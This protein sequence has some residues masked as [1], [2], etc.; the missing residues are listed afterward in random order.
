MER[1]LLKIRVARY[2]GFCMGVRRAVNIAIDSAQRGNAPVYTLGSLIHNPQVVEALKEKGVLPV[3]SVRGKP[4]GRVI[5]R[6][7]GI[8]PYLR[9]EIE[10]SGFG[11]IDATCPH[12]LR[13]Q[14]II[15]KYCAEG[16]TAVIV[17]DRGHAEVSALLGYARARGVGVIVESEEEAQSL[18]LPGES[19]SDAKLCVVAQT[20]QDTDLYRRVCQRI[21]SRFP[22][23]IICDTICVS[24]SARQETLRELCSQVDAVVVVGGKE[25]ANTARLAEIAASYPVT[26]FHIEQAEELNPEQFKEFSSVGVTAGASTP[27]W[28][29]RSVVKRLKSFG[30]PRSPVATAAK[31]LVRFLVVSNIYLASGAAALC[32]AVSL[33][34]GIAWRIEYS[35]IAFLYIF[36]VHSVNQYISVHKLPFL[37]SAETERF[38]ASLRLAVAGIASGL[39]AMGIS[40]LLGYV[41]FGLL[42]VALIFGLTYSARLLPP[43]LFRLSRL[44]DLPGSKD[45]FSALGWAFVVSLF[46][47][48]DSLASEKILVCTLASLFVFLLVYIRS[49]LLDIGQIQ[50][51]RAVG[52]EVTP[53]FLGKE[54]MKFLLGAAVIAMLVLLASGSAFGILTTLGWAL[55]AV[56]AYSALYLYLY[57]KRV[58]DQEI[59]FEL[60]VDGNFL[61]AGFVAAIYQYFSR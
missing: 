13:T 30:A 46:P 52:R 42:L 53:F 58:V 54:K 34:Q 28:V 11:I 12:V 55:I 26:V 6:S 14:K 21:K 8:S 25:S 44:K 61:L 29:I 23:T 10:S 47:A 5:I 48:A 43:R 50:Q 38:K 51:D 57:H 35:A 59:L 40:L 37:F 17:G 19:D 4:P 56:V 24:T 45:L 39:A 1:Q 32:F 16:Y 41:Q 18:H 15:E 60:V 31:S 9:E 2:A 20:T 7:H 22:N 49:S 27:N 33:L 36:S 3:D